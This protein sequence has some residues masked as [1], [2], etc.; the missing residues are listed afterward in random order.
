VFSTPYSVSVIVLEEI[1]LSRFTG[2]G[3]RE[4]REAIRCIFE[5]INSTSMLALKALVTS[6]MLAREIRK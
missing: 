3:D 4:G 5:V 1:T 6:T 2:E